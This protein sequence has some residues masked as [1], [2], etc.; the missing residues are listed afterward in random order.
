MGKDQDPELS[1]SKGGLCD[2]ALL[3][4]LLV[5]LGIGL[6][7]TDPRGQV[8]YLSPLA[9]KLTGWGT[10]EARGRKIE[11]VYQVTPS[12]SERH[13]PSSSAEGLEEAMLVSRT[14][15]RYPIAQTIVPRRNEE[16]QIRALIIAFQDISRRKLADLQL[17]RQAT[18]DGLTGLL[19][20]EAF[21]ASVDGAFKSMRSKGQPFA[22]CQIDLDQFNLVNNTC[23]HTA[24]DTLLQWV[25]SLLREEVRETDVLARLAGDVFG[26]V[27]GDAPVDEA[28]RVVESVYERLQHFQFTWADKTF[29]IG[30]SIGLVPVESGDWSVNDVLRAADHAC[31]MAKKGGRNQIHISTLEDEEITVRREDEEWVARIRKNLQEGGVTLFAQPILP[32]SHDEGGQLHFEVLLRMTGDDG[33]LRSAG[34]VIRATERYGLM[35]SIDRWVVRHTLET[36]RAQPSEVLD[37]VQLCSINLSGGSLHDRTLL[38]YVQQQ[39]AAARIPPRLLCFEI[40]ETAA[41][42]NLEQARWFIGELSAIGCRFALDDFG[43]GLAS[44]G[45]IKDLPVDF[46]KIS[47]EFVENIASSPL[48][49]ALVESINQIG[50]VL[51]IATVAEAV[52]SQAALEA[53]LTIGVDYAQGLWV[54]PPRPLAEVLAPQAQ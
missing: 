23:G 51:G 4:T 26:L 22:V 36:L 53:V 54:G 7:R 42:D 3:E 41:V 52:S 16:G 10:T 37:R 20:R 13:L 32:L 1:E 38:E 27:L 48:D 46:L 31:A 45:Y 40:T 50:K 24:G 14:G 28:R 21:A 35:A 19:N 33:L 44:Y 34:R 5:R 18:H 29:S 9:E 39:L 11:R 12:T 17:T 6:I 8:E 49:R 15:Q 47:G 2:Q 43:S 30:A 25:A